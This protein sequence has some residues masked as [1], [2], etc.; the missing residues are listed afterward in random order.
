MKNIYILFFTIILTISSYGQIETFQGGKKQIL[1]KTNTKPTWQWL[2]GKW[3][4]MGVIKNQVL[5]T[6]KAY[7]KTIDSLQKIILNKEI[8][9]DSAKLYNLQIVCEVLNL[10]R[11]S[12]NSFKLAFVEK[13]L[14]MYDFYDMGDIDTDLSTSSED[15]V[16]YTG[17]FKL[18]TK[19]KRIVLKTADTDKPIY[20]DY[21]VY[22]DKLLIQSKD[23][24]DGVSLLLEKQ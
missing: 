24:F 22:G 13:N 16:T 19:Q 7:S 9:M 20:I 17:T 8:A 18:M 6:E 11:F 4:V 14:F 21:Q 5:Y 2:E 3:T 12:M 1:N 23:L 10:F 15:I